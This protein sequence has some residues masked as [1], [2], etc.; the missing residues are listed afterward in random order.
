MTEK[1]KV[2]VE[3][4]VLRKFR[5]LEEENELLRLRVK[6]QKESIEAL[7]DVIAALQSR[8]NLEGAM[9]KT[10]IELLKAASK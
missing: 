5:K 3:P 10:D 6:Y 1:R 2:K 9:N 7:R 4:V 8:A